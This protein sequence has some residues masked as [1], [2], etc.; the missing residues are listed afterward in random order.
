MSKPRGVVREPV[1]FPASEA[2]TRRVWQPI[3]LHVS[4]TLYRSQGSKAW[5][6]AKQRRFPEFGSVILRSAFCDDLPNLWLS[7]QRMSRDGER[8]RRNTIDRRRLRILCS[9]AVPK[10]R[11]L[12]SRRLSSGITLFC[13]YCR[14][15]HGYGSHTGCKTL[16]KPAF[17]VAH[18]LSLNMFQLENLVQL[19]VYKDLLVW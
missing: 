19:C 1:R 16:Q 8:K 7:W 11:Q 4:A 2:L 14:C 17:V 12:S 6:A 10:T 13:P 18:R 3:H 5:Y 15:M 9:Q